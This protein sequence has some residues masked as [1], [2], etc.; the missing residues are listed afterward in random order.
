MSYVDSTLT[1][2]EV[3][4]YRAKVHWLQ[5]VWPI[6]VLAALLT[7]GSFDQPAVVIM[8][9]FFLV[10]AVSEGIAFLTTELAVTSKRV[11]G[12][13]GL[14]SRTTIEQ[15]LT[16]VDSVAVKQSILGRLLGYGSVTVN[17]SGLSASPARFISSPLAYRRAVQEA[18][19]AA[20]KV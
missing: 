1:Q 19:E 20:G 18:V 17:G 15:L 14:F 16:K 5:F 12:K 3:V 10:A 6:L 11:V 4:L 8:F 9:I 2:G 7:L 13:F